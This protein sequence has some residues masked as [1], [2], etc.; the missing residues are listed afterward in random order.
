MADLHIFLEFA[1]SAINPRS[2]ISGRVDHASGGLGTDC[3]RWH[4]VAVAAGVVT[5]RAIWALPEPTVATKPSAPLPD[6]YI[7]DDKLDLGEVWESRDAVLTVPISNRTDK[8]I[9][10][11][12][13]KAPATAGKSRL[14]D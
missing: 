1:C 13:S 9:E 10:T 14:A 8:P 12:T 4:R 2:I 3:S 5:G 7:A 11:S 6:L